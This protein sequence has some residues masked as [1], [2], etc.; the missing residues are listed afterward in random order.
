MGNSDKGMENIRTSD[1]SMIP[2][3]GEPQ[4]QGIE[5]NIPVRK[6]N[7]HRKF[8]FDTMLCG[9]TYDKGNTFNLF[10]VNGLLDRGWTAHGNKIEGHWLTKDGIE[11]RFDIRIST[12]KACV[13]CGYFERVLDQRQTIVHDVDGA[14]EKENGNGNSKPE[15]D[16]ETKHKAETKTETATLKTDTETEHHISK[17]ETETKQQQAEI[18]NRNE[19]A[20]LLNLSLTERAIPMVTIT[21]T[22][23]DHG[24]ESNTQETRISCGTNQESQKRQNNEALGGNP[25]G[26]FFMANNVQDQASRE[27][28]TT[29]PETDKITLEAEQ[30]HNFT[31]KYSSR[32]SLLLK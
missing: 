18:G 9:A 23:H 2:A 11:V 16:K 13:W 26:Y 10:G 6:L 17:T 7:R 4:K 15:T 12:A 27:G 25:C 3:H 30:A 32:S 22:L 8:E 28:T 31:K 14:I 1:S 5:G 29:K 21:D 19:N 20:S 24:R